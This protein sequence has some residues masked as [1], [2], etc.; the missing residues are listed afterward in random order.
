MS[1]GYDV[2]CPSPGCGAALCE[3]WHRN[4]LWGKCGNCERYIEADERGGYRLTR[5]SLP[6]QF[7]DE[8]K[9]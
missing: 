7:R 9:P 2:I 1:Q 5:E 4:V 3:R 8:V 6:S